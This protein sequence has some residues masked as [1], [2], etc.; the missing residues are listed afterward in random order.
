M[1]SIVENNVA[2]IVSSFPAF[3]TFLRLHVSETAFVKSLLGSRSGGGSH[4]S[5]SLPRLKTW[6]GGY[7]ETS[8]RT[9]VSSANGP[10]LPAAQVYHHNDP[11]PGQGEPAGRADGVPVGAGG[12]TKTWI[13]ST[14]WGGQAVGIK[15]SGAQI[16]WTV[17]IDQELHPSAMV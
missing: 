2:I 12:G 5:F 16:V 8:S 15:P 9:D 3:A 6:K 4:P 7:S 10:G 1:N 13:Q 17:D 14:P 11:F